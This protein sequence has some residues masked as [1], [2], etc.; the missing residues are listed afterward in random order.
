MGKRW[1]KGVA[2][3]ALAG[4]LVAGC[5]TPQGSGQGQGQ[6]TAPSSTAEATAPSETAPVPTGPMPV[7]LL[8]PMTGEQAQTGQALASA[9]RD[10]MTLAG[11]PLVRLSLHD[12][13]GTPEG[14]RAAAQ[15]AVTEG[16]ELVLG[17]LFSVSAQAAR[18]VLAAADI[19]ALSF[20]NNSA[21]AGGGLYVLGHLP[22]QQTR[23]L[24]SHAATQGYGRIAV[25]G[26]DTSYARQVADAARPRSGPG[27]AGGLTGAASLE[28]F[29]ASLE[30]D[31]QVKLIGQMVKQ[32]LS[33]ALIPTTGLNL[34]GLSAL[35]AYYDAAPPDFRL[36]GTDLWEWP[37]TF[38]E[39][40]LQEAWYVST[41][42]PPAWIDERTEARRLDRAVAAAARRSAPETR[43][44]RPAAPEPADPPDETE[45]TTEDAEPEAAADAVA[46]DAATSVDDGAETETD[47]E[48]ETDAEPEPLRLA[49]GPTKLARLAMDGVALAEAWTAA[50]RDGA[51]GPAPSLSRFLTDPA[52]FRG[53]SGLFRLLPSGLNERGLF[54]LEVHEDGP[55]VIRPAPV[56]FG[57][58]QAPRM[59]VGPDDFERHPWLAAEIEAQTPDT[60]P[61]LTPG[62]DPEADPEADG[63]MPPL[64]RD[65]D[66]GRPDAGGSPTPVSAPA[67]AADDGCRW[68]GSRRV[69]TPTS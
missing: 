38:S 28:L 17:P 35:F 62:A 31:A 14:A 59:L 30:Y 61:T 63:A 12:T 19:P 66:G 56:R 43:P 36:L 39:G 29:P 4:L 21:V 6:A 5:A 50:R 32:D 47:A 53:F 25:V 64:A 42:T 3:S 40:S 45:A 52:G 55:R 7:A 44:A 8:V 58:T 69:C 54:V 34:V 41:S 15:A 18:P 26:P 57:T 65:A 60:V 24:L 49:I 33:G 27:P 16:A 9:A 46:E 67:P 13:R 37:G 68:V 1:A 11:M 51:A 20:S 23:T 2:A 48:A 22:G 10:A